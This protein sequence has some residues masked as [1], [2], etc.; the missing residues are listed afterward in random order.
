MYGGFAGSAG[1]VG[2]EG[3]ARH[4][5]QI[6]AGKNQRPLVSFFAGYARV[7][8]DVLQL[9]SSATSHRPHA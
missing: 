4:P 2:V 6:L 9:T 7:Y 1:G 3:D 5:C 8:K